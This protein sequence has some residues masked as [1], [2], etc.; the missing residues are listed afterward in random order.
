MV[1]TNGCVPIP[2]QPLSLLESPAGC[3]FAPRCSDAQP[4]RCD[5]R[6]PELTAVG[7]GRE[8][9]CVRAAEVATMLPGRRAEPGWTR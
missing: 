8:V 1:R 5:G 6:T 4:G 9:A 3:S 7:A 2:G